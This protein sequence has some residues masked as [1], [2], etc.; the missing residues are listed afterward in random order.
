VKLSYVVYEPVPDF[1]ELSARMAVLAE[2]GY[3][4]VE[5]HATHPLGFA[6]EDLS[7]RAT[8]LS[9]PVVS[10]L[11]GWSYANEGLSLSTPDR[12][13]RDRAV[14]RLIEYVEMAAKLEALLVVGLLQGLRSDEPDPAIATDRIAEAVS[15]VAA[16]AEDRGV[17]IVVEP[18]NH[19]QVGFTHTA[20]EATDL[21]ARIGS[22]AVGLMLDTI[23]L[24]IEEHAMLDVI[25]EH[26]ERLGHFHLAD[27]NGGL[28][29][30]GNLDFVAVL[31]AL[32]AAGY[33]RYVSVKVYR[34]PLW[35]VAA[36]SALAY[37]R[38]VRAAIA[39]TTA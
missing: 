12:S 14:A 8:E 13:V 38:E 6:V 37:V 11:S 36:R 3:D 25:R 17:S 22:P 35:D 20:A 34:T 16:V 1:A 21:V 10:L 24:N 18:V 15:R 27:T 33:D 7:A 4:G 5:I 28:Y 39:A 30:T 23:H 9:L 19:L 31:G 32:D 2:L 29:G 26:G